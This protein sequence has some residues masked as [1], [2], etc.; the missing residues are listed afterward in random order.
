MSESDWPIPW[1]PVAGSR[2][3]VLASIESA[4][5]EGTRGG[6]A[7]LPLG[8]QDRFIDLLA[9]AAKAVDK[10]HTKAAETYIAT[11]LPSLPDAQRDDLVLQSWR[12]FLTMLVRNAAFD[13][14]VPAATRLTH[15]ELDFSPEARAIFETG[16]SCI[17]VS[18]HLGDFEAGAALFPAIGFRHFYAVAKPPKNRPLSLATQRLRESRGYRV[19]NRRGAWTDLAKIVAA[20]GSVALLLDQRPF[21]KAVI[22][23]FFGR[24]TRCER[25]AA[26]LLRRLEVPVV[27]GACLTTDTPYRYKMSFR[28]VLEPKELTGQTPE[29][30]VTRVNAE[31]ESLILRYP[32]QY[33][34][35]HDR[36]R[37]DAKV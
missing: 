21:G 32:E 2:T 34:W 10:R 19:I 12:Y 17:A 3:G 35:L 27:V 7:R 9:R 15:Y 5:A 33:F 30:I 8:I 28:T 20:G 22:A 36:F 26:V 29:Q 13:R 6:L 37:D 11:A 25:G 18:P 16:A 31:M 4:L 14:R 23:P 24:M 1:A